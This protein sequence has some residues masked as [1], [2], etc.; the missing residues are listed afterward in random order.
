MSGSIQTNSYFRSAKTYGYPVITTLSGGL[1]ISINTVDN[2]NVIDFNP[3]VFSGAGGVSVEVVDN[4]VVVSSSLSGES[5]ISQA[6]PDVF[7]ARQATDV[8]T[9]SKT[10]V[11][12]GSMSGSMTVQNFSSILFNFATTFTISSATASFVILVDSSQISGSKIAK[13]AFGAHET[14]TIDCVTEPLSAGTHT[15]AVHWR[16]ADAAGTLSCN[17]SSLEGRQT[18]WLIAQEVTL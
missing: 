5:Q 15:F 13:Y 3:T 2:V 6:F 1:G 16:V 4:V 8:Q 18:A 11:Q 7:V 14:A 12:M 9:T 10:F 17:A